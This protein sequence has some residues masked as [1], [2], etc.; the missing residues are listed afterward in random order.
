VR[1]RMP[2]LCLMAVLLVASACSDD[3][4]TTPRSELGWHSLGLEEMT[5]QSLELDYPYLYAC[6]GRHGLYRGNVAKANGEWE[7]L[8][9]ASSTYPD[10]HGGSVHDVLVLDD[11]TILAAACYYPEGEGE[12]PPSL[13]R[14]EDNGKTWIPSDDGLVQDNGDFCCQNPLA[15][16]DHY[17]YVGSYGCG[18]F[19]SEDGGLRWD[20][21]GAQLGWWYGPE[22]LEHSP[23]DC[24]VIWQAGPTAIEESRMAVSADHGATWTWLEPLRGQWI[25]SGFALD[26]ADVNTAYVA[27]HRSMLKTTDLGSSFEVMLELP[28]RTYATAL[29]CGRYSGQ[30]FAAIAVN[31]T[32]A[33]ENFIY[34][35]RQGKTVADTLAIPITGFVWDMLADNKRRTIYV[36]G[37][38]GVYQY[39]Y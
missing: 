26:A 36:A 23:V 11:S 2:S 39:V 1:F 19:K 33:R 20:K 3:C 8:G 9:L 37:D 29:S 22:W 15:K 4:P 34:E 38:G 17:I 12:F 5:V 14:S 25:V 18:I 35:I 7:H 28:E 30:V 27:T 31:S 21:S 32:N 10:I 16:C 24:S 6:V 13:H